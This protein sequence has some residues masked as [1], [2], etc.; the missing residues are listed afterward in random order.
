MGAGG[1]R[2]GVRRARCVL[3]RPVPINLCR[4]SRVC[5][6]VFAKPTN[7]KQLIKQQQGDGG[8]KVGGKDDREMFKHPDLPGHV[9][10]PHPRKGIPMGTLRNIY[11]QAGPLWRIDSSCART[12]IFI[13]S[14][15]L[16][17]VGSVVISELSD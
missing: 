1:I 12:P 8:I 16:F 3:P 14:D 15:R 5:I 2:H 13:G 9:V 10:I 4:L 7:S 11:R 6:R 17:R